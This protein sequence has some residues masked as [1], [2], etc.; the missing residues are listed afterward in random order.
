LGVGVVSDW[1][2]F[3]FN[4]LTNS[5]APSLFE[6]SLDVEDDEEDNVDESKEDDDVDEEEELLISINGFSFPISFLSC[7]FADGSLE[8]SEE[9]KLPMGI[10]LCSSSSIASSAAWMV[11]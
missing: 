10:G 5:W 6:L 9:D 3:V 7:C 8:G 11:T 1:V 2:V 4:Q